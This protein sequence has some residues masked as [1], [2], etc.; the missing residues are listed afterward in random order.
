[1]LSE[2]KILRLDFKAE[3]E[4]DG[5]ALNAPLLH[6]NAPHGSGGS[7][8]LLSACLAAGSPTAKLVGEA[9]R[10]LQ[11]VR[12]TVQVASG[13]WLLT[14]DLTR[15]LARQEV[16][17][18]C[19]ATGEVK[20]LPVK[21]QGGLQSA[22][23]F[24]VDLLGLPVVETERG[25]VTADALLRLL[26]LPQD[27]TVT[28]QVGGAVGSQDCAATWELAAGLLDGPALRERNRYRATAAD[29]TKAERKLTQLRDA[30]REHGQASA[31]ELDDRER[32]HRT[33]S[34][35]ALA[36]IKDATTGVEEATRLHHKRQQAADQAQQ[37]YREARDAAQQAAGALGPRYEQLGV[38]R[39]RLEEAEARL[40]GPTHCPECTRRLPDR[41]ACRT[42]GVLDDRDAANRRLQR[43]EEATAARRALQRAEKA[44]EEARGAER[45][46]IQRQN[47]AEREAKRLYGEAEAH[48]ATQIATAQHTLEQARARQREA[49]LQLQAA[50]ELRKELR[51]V[52]EAE[53][54]LAHHTAQ[55]KEAEYAWQQAESAAAEQRTRRAKEL[56]E[57]F[58]PMLKRMSPDVLDARIEEK[59]FT[60]LVN[61]K[62]PRNLSVHGGLRIL[63]HLA[64]QLTLFTAAHTLPGFRLPAIA[65][66]DSPLDSLG[67]AEEEQAAALRAIQ[68]ASALAGDRGQIILKT[69]HSLPQNHP[70]L[71]TQNLDTHHRFIPHL[72]LH[73]S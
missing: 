59:D 58:A 7:T 45:Q 21:S 69:P 8:A 18:V 73:Q 20:P 48:R 2:L 67:A 19:E 61:T 12:L 66:L 65:W 4:W 30:R 28:A 15:D 55:A 72:Q 29:R 14:R 43:Q 36:A 60:P 46:A 42:C 70:G 57:I 10:Q 11:A 35:Q 50:A 44:L 52:I 25:T 27:R 1:M 13:R 54:A 49:Q 41:P 47:A 53:R 62:H 26:T 17:F 56:T 39:T 32:R 51:E 6:F 9:A 37:T 22:G 24:F 38:A 71:R 16:E 63:V 40:G 33:E 5:R 64:W 68:E 23:A 31:Q 34:D 3:G